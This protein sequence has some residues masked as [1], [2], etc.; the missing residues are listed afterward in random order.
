MS[1]N[2]IIQNNKNQQN[3]FEQYKDAFGECFSKKDLV[4]IENNTSSVIDLK[5]IPKVLFEYIYACSLNG[6]GL[7][8]SHKWLAEKLGCCITSIKNALKLLRSLGLVSWVSGRGNYMTNQYYVHISLLA[9]EAVRILKSYMKCAWLAWCRRLLRFSINISIL[10]GAISTSVNND[11]DEKCLPRN[12]NKNLNIKNCNCTTVYYCRSDLHSSEKRKKMNVKKET[13]ENLKV[14]GFNFNDAARCELQAFDDDI[15]ITACDQYSF[16][17][18]KKEVDN[19]WLV[20]MGITKRICKDRAYNPQYS[21]ASAMKAQYG[22]TESPNL[23]YTKP[24]SDNYREK[25]SSNGKTTGSGTKTTHTPDE[26]GWTYGVMPDG[27]KVRS[28]GFQGR[29]KDDPEDSGEEKIASVMGQIASGEWYT[30]FPTKELADKTATAMIAAANA[31]IAGDFDLKR[32]ILFEHLA[33]VSQN[34]IKL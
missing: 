14:K 1:L 32:K 11:S 22:I 30:R 4:A 3:I 33:S 2:L 17:Y 16:S 18:G 34:T 21:T 27:T 8:M 29:T 23:E 5:N 20:F 19:P 6:R 13:F 10:S 12:K 26:Q 9:H 24:A 25:T 28:R 31:Q 7:W 15:V